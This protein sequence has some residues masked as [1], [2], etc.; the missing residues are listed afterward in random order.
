MKRFTKVL[1]LAM[2]LAMTCLLLAS[3]GLSGT[4]K[5]NGLFGFG[6]TELTFKGSKITVEL[7][8][9]EAEGTYKIKDDKITIEF[10]D[11]NEDEATLGDL[12]QLLNGEHSFEKGDDYI[13]IGG[14]KYTK[15]D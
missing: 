6:A 14:T 11:E 3:C 4:Y 7:G 10:P 1:A 13:K 9:V 8:G 12:F 15:A 2:V 5:N